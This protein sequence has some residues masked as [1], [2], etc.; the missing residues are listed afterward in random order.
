M[1]PGCAASMR[2]RSN[3]R[4]NNG[5]VIKRH[6]NLM[7]SMRPRSNDRGNES[8]HFWFPLIHV[9]SMRPRSNDRGN[10]GMGEPVCCSERI[11]S[12]RPRSNDRGNRPVLLFFNSAYTRFNEAAI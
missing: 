3:D 11:A 6:S 8:K 5:N 1:P 12:M 10:P 2:P 4:G 7:A 9:A